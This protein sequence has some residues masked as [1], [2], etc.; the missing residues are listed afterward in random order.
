M[1]NFRRVPK[2]PIYGMAQPT[3]EVTLLRRTIIRC[4][5]GFVNAMAHFS[6]SPAGDGSRSGVSDGREE[7]AQQCFVGEFAG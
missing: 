4:K 1:A 6:R 7:E 5:R 3:S 2:M